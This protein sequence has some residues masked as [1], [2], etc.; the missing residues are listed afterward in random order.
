MGTDKR[1]RKKANRNAKLEAERAAAARAR[2]N[3]TIRN[4]VVAGV[5]LVAMMFLMSALTGCSSDG[6]DDEF[7]F[8][9]DGSEESTGSD[10]A[11]PTEPAPTAE[12]PSAVPVDYGTGPCP[13]PEGVGEPVVDFPDA[14]EQCIDPAKAYTATFETSMGTIVVELDTE[15]SPITTNNFVTLARYGY[16]EG[17]DIH[18][19]VASAG[20]VQGG[21]PKTND[22][23][24]PGPGYTIPDEGGV[25]TAED[26]T[27]G[28]LAMARTGAPNSAGGQF[29]F[30]ADESGTDALA[31]AGTYVVFGQVTEGL[32]ILQA[33]AALDDGFEAPSEQIVLESV[34]IA[35]A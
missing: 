20:F 24:D 23:S 21:S 16:Y 13:P 17:T 12:D 27:P 28:I 7:T 22:A 9:S 35:E 5:A 15:R 2:R 11:E 25:F 18:R 29:F 26:Y 30:L 10:D 31:S 6:G 3:R 8:L 33:M 34:T 19:V 32:E 4:I 1:E 14:P